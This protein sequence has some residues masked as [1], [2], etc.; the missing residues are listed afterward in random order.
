MS[1]S[2]ESIF[3]DWI[4]MI[5]DQP[6]ISE[7]KISGEEFVDRLDELDVYKSYELAL[8]IKP[9]MMFGDTKLE[10]MDDLMWITERNQVVIRHCDEYILLT[11]W[12]VGEEPGKQM[13]IP[14]GEADLGHYKTKYPEYYKQLRNLEVGQHVRLGG[15]RFERVR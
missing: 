9:P 15:S 10:S 4:K 11:E 6:M 7:T 3:K 12:V 1:N 2:V 13:P 14:R 5:N 8:G